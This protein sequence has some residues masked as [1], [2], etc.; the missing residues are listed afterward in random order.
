[1]HV[2]PHLSRALGVVERERVLPVPRQELFQRDVV[3]LWFVGLDSLSDVEVERVGG[4]AAAAASAVITSNR[5]SSSALLTIWTP[6]CR[7]ERDRGR[8][9]SLPVATGTQQAG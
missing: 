6:N 9:V 1:M 8:R 7:Y 3:A 4:H 5:L 2:H